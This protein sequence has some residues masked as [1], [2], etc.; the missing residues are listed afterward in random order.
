MPPNVHPLPASCCF[1]HFQIFGKIDSFPKQFLNV[2]RIKKANC[3]F[4]ELSNSYLTVL[5]IS[6]FPLLLRV[7]AEVEKTIYLSCKIRRNK[8]NTTDIKTALDYLSATAIMLVMFWTERIHSTTNSKTY[9]R[10]KNLF[11]AANTQSSFEESLKEKR[12]KFIDICS[13]FT[14]FSV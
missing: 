7:T 10:A 6:F 1:C 8:H 12:H 5:L 11:N 14:C 13:L 2:F 4:E 9:E 3:I